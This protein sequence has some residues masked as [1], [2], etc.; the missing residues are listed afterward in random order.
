MRGVPEQDPVKDA[1]GALGHAAHG[2]ALRGVATFLREEPVRATRLVGQLLKAIALEPDPAKAARA[3]VAAG[4]AYL[5]AGSPERARE[6][7]VKG[8]ARLG[9]ADVPAATRATLW[10]ARAELALGNLRAAK[11]LVARSVDPVLALDEEDALLDLA[12]VLR[13]TGED[14]AALLVERRRREARRAG[15]AA[16]SEVRLE[17]VARLTRALGS[18]LAGTKEPLHDIVRAVLDETGAD[19]GFLMLYGEKALRFELGLA[20]DGQLLGPD[21]FRYSS[22]I[23]EAA[24]KEKRAVLVPDLE[25]SLSFAAASSARELGLRSAL[26][27]PL[28]AGKRRH[29]AS[30]DGAELLAKDGAAGVLYVDARSKGSFSERDARFFGTLAA[31]ATVA[32]RVARTAALLREYRDAET[33]EQALARKGRR[34]ARST[35]AADRAPGG[36]VFELGGFVTRDPA[37]R[38]TLGLLDRV[39]AEA[40]G[41]VVRGETGTGK[42]LVA[43][44]I[45]A[46]G[47]RAAGPFVA[48]DC[49]AL[50]DDLAQ[51]TFFGHV[52][53]A[54]TGALADKPGLVEQADG[55]TLFL[56][57]V[58]ELTP[59]VQALLLRV[60]Q[61]GEVRR[62][63]SEKTR[64]VDVRVVAATSR[65]LPALVASG[66]LRQDL[67]FRLVVVELALPPLRERRG[68]VPLLVERFL[69]DAA[70]RTGGAP[71]AIEPAALA[72]LEEHAWP[73][74]VRE[75]EN[76]LSRLLLA[77]PGALTLAHV[78]SALALSPASSPAVSTRAPA[79]VLDGTL[80]EV[81][82]RTVE[83]RLERFDW[84]QAKVA[85]SL[86]MDPRTLYR[87]IRRWGLR[88][89]RR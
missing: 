67:Y 66:E 85:E 22:T 64:R 20:R 34:S 51:E 37:L 52:A 61:E 43:R 77:T 1:L 16:V 62:L 50:G 58:G 9:P 86:G 28:V 8:A 19:R 32:V 68:D 26:C 88:R 48:V 10:I 79:P 75:L 55:G 42:E 41:V 13:G 38:A 73:G 78:E 65:D 25:Q 24:L 54:F 39:A 3:E 53:G 11:E 45:H 44:A 18:S 76:A 5:A 46:R 49:G 63:G 14:L 84:N 30:A 56:D 23:V 87:K 60:L 21:D 57:E 4:A 35:V 72:R 6:L 15:D 69:A 59:N 40:G 29:G 82:R 83:A 2:D 80:E 89:S 71:R 36:G 33:E 31:C 7:L 27:A 70:R 81:E 47:P 12:L 17:L 74:N